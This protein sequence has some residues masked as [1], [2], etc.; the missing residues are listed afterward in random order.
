MVWVLDFG[1]LQLRLILAPIVDTAGL[2]VLW[3]RSLYGQNNGADAITVA[4]FRRW[5]FQA[6]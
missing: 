5:C 4:F 2:A 3:A 1:F 6:L